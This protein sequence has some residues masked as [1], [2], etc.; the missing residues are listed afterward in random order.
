MTSISYRWVIASL[1]FLALFA[2]MGTRASFGAYVLSWEESFGASRGE[3]SFISSLS[4]IVFGLGMVV[5]GQLADRFGTRK[6]V[7]TSF[8]LSGI[9]LL[10]SSLATSLWHM[11]ILY[12][13]IVSLGS[14]G[15]S[16]VTLSP[17]VMKWFSDRRGLA[18][19]FSNSGIAVG[20]MALVPLSIY[21]IRAFDWQTSLQIFGLAYLAL[22]APVFWFLYRDN[23]PAAKS[24]DDEKNGVTVEPVQ[25]SASNSATQLDASP[26]PRESLVAVMWLLVTWMIIAPYFVCGFTDIGLF[27]THFIPLS[28][29]RGFSSEII[30]FAI[31][32]SSIAT[33]G[34]AVVTGY[35]TDTMRLTTLL[36]LTYALRGGSLVL[37]L[38]ANSPSLLLIFGMLH[39]ITTVATIAP[40]TTLC[41][42]VYGYHRVGSVF[43]VMSLFHQFGAA[44]GSFIP[45]LLFDLTASYNVAL[46]LSASML[47]MGSVITWMVVEGRR[48]TTTP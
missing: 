4:F 15:T 11:I 39:G 14:S 17:G 20:Q 7:V 32:L 43:G 9:S 13:V 18:L 31:T 16:P 25:E 48:H 6:V 36:S 40:T 38:F 45:G 21:L 29:G 27:N 37:L 28:E 3:V 26:K 2:S 35:L 34:G 47:A 42:R 19:G 23:L 41:A 30:V 24:P 22:L 33:L 46:I 5:G 1:S 12:G 10:A 44:A 8:V